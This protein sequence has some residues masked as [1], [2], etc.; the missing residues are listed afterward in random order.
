MRNEQFRPYDNPE[1]VQ[2]YGQTYSVFWKEFPFSIAEDFAHGVQSTK[3][4]NGLVL[5]IGSGLGEEA[6][7]LRNLG[8]SPIGFDGA[9]E[10]VKGS[11]R[12]N[13]TSVRGSFLQLSFKKNIFDGVWAYKSLCH[14]ENF[15]QLDAALMEVRRVLKPMGIFGWCMLQGKTDGVAEAFLDGTQTRSNFYL[16]EKT[17]LSLLEDY[18]FGIEVTANYRRGQTNYLMANATKFGD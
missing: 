9:M 11:E 14:A 8:L 10:M 5:C 15:N 12:K 1:T 13:I 7:I 3:K 6:V 2:Y 16:R 4:S 17:F 18:N